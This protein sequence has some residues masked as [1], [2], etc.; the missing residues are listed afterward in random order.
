M[1]FDN[2]KTKINQKKFLDKAEEIADSVGLRMNFEIT[3]VL[4]FICIFAKCK[5]KV[6][7]YSKNHLSTLA[8]LC[9]LSGFI[10]EAFTVAYYSDSRAKYISTIVG[11]I[12]F[13]GVM[14]VTLVIVAQFVA[15]FLLLIRRQVE[16]SVVV[17]LSI[18]LIQVFYPYIGF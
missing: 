13:I 8:R 11:G 2:I 4:P 16:I 18:I 9:L 6:L 7:K 15:S 14:I 1:N 17:L 10:S 12:P 3:F 5:S